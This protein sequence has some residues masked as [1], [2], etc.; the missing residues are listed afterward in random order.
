MIRGLVETHWDGI[1]KAKKEAEDGKLTVGVSVV[2]EKD[3]YG[4]DVAEV[5]ISYGVKV[6]DSATCRLED[7]KQGK[8][9]YVPKPE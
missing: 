9:E 5:K 8:L 6:K 4:N 7:P 2:L 1:Q 3:K